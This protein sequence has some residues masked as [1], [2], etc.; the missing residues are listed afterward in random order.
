MK[1][2]SVVGQSEIK[3]K[4]KG[5]AQANRVPHAMMLLGPEG[6]GGLAMA[7]A[8][9]QYVNCTQRTD[10]DS[11]GS[12]SSC[13]AM[14]KLV[15][16]NVHFT[17]PVI[18][19]EKQ[20]DPPVSSQ[21]MSEWREAVH[22]QP[23]I[24][25]NDWLQ[26][27][28]AEN[29]QGNI[30]VRECHEIIRHI[31]LKTY[32]DGYKIQIIWMAELLKEAGNTLLKII[33][34]PPPQTIFILIVEN[35]EQV[36]TTILSRT[37]IVKLPQIEDAD[38]S[39]ALTANFEMDAETAARIARISEGNYHAAQLYATGNESG[40]DKRLHKWL[41]ACYNL[42]LKPSGSNTANLFEWVE[43]T[44]KIGRE[45]QKMFLKYALFLDRKSVV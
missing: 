42:K 1:F 14:Q 24:N 31:N 32:D 22:A 39:A 43:E 29:K 5:M 25:L 11:C 37:Q 2:A 13:N 3:Q 8:L 36:L 18:K 19:P 33:E 38:I 28:K 12:C 20:K 16:P 30:T 27:I 21:Y 10:D 35:A 45:N 4:L 41:V 9:A 26:A 15:H 17:F 6:S 7:L 44:A 23:Y 34:E 40:N